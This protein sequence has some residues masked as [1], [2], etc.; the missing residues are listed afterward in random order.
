[1]ISSFARPSPT[2]AGSRD[3]PPT[4]G[5]R[6]I[7]V[8]GIPI[9]ASAAITRRSHASASSI[10]PPMHAPWIWQIVG[11]VISSARF[12]ASRHRRRN[13]R[14][15]SGA[16]ASPARA[17]RSMPEENIGPAPRTTTQRTAVSSAAARSA[18]PVASTSSPLN[19]LRFSGR[20][21]DDVADGAVVFGQHEGHGRHPRWVGLRA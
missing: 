1:M 4:S 2:T 21:E 3:E 17:A 9:T 19:A 11:L 14:R 15:C 10:A 13:A 7:R 20:F 16:S 5:I 8:S 12:Q 6:P 18:S